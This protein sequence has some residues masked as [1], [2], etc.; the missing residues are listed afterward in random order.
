MDRIEFLR[1]KALNLCMSDEFYYLFFTKYEKLTDMPEIE[2]YAEAFDYMFSNLAPVIFPGELIVGNRCGPMSQQMNDEWESKYRAQALEKA[3]L[4]YGQD[5]HMTIDY[6]L[7]LSKG[8]NGII[9]SIDE[10]IKNCDEDKLA[11]YKC[12]KRCLLAILKH[13]N[14]YSEHALKLSNETDDEERK[15]ELI[16]IAEICKKVPSEPAETFK[17]AIQSVHFVTHCITLNP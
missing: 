14:A 1:D 15:A 3:K 9:Q 16:K 6:D 11:F 2:R 8:I 13:A 12:A 17:E 10:Y 4:S 5:S 7:L